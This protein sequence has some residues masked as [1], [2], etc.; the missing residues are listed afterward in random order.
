ME[1]RLGWAHIS[2][3]GSEAMAWFKFK[4]RPQVGV[5]VL[6]KLLLSLQASSPGRGP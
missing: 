2:V 5:G 3:K 1:T 6:A 4:V